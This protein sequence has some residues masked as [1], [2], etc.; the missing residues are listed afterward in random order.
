MCGMESQIGLRG[1]L[2]EPIYF[3]FPSRYQLAYVNEMQHFLDVI[4]G[5]DWPFSNG[6]QPFLIQV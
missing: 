5:D 3:S 6:S 1:S 4:Q 2:V